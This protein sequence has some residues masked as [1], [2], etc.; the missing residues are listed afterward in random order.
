[1]SQYSYKEYVENNF[2]KFVKVELND[3]TIE[4]VKSFVNEIISVKQRENHHQIDSSMEHKRW[5]TG[6]LGECAVEKFIGKF[7]VD[8]SIGISKKYHVPDLTSIGIDCG[9]KTVEF[10]KF[11][12]V[13]IK[14]YK[15]EI[16]VIKKSE[17]FFYICGLASKEVLN[18]YQSMSLVLSPLLRKRGTKTGFYGFH[19]LL[20]PST[21]LELID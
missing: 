5:T 10:G 16:I 11:P 14:S 4:K 21:I 20:P 3:N 2:N 9:I 12:I 17:K 1:M 19:K 7:F 8:F 15:P 13:F 6:F 18:K